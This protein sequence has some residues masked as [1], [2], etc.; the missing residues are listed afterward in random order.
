MSSKE[1]KTEVDLTHA[2]SV[3]YTNYRG[4]TATRTIVPVEGKLY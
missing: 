3:E 1:S 4:E 2:L